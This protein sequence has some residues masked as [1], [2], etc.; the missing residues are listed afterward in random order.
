MKIFATVI[1]F[2]SFIPASKA[3]ISTQIIEKEYAF[4][5]SSI[6]EMLTHVRNHGPKVTGIDT[7]ASLQAEIDAKYGVISDDNGC[8]FHQP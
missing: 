5:A 4:S 2:F 6:E 3:E 7:W 8:Q 1:L